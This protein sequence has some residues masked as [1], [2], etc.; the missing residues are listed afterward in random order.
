MSTD[1]WECHIRHSNSIYG[2]VTSVGIG[3]T[4]MSA[5]FC[6]FSNRASG[7]EGRCWAESDEMLDLPADSLWAFI[8]VWRDRLRLY[9]S[10]YTDWKRNHLPVDRTTFQS[11]TNYLLLPASCYRS[12]SHK[13]VSVQ[14]ASYGGNPSWD[15]LLHGSLLYCNL[16]YLTLCICHSLQLGGG[17]AGG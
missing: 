15:R 7:E 11:C 9:M 2:T 16:L 8:T 13:T 14:I 3:T 1:K 10:M 5:L 6:S 12:M 4:L 17:V